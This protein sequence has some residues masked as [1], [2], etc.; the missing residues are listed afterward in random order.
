M[1]L[2]VRVLLVHVVEHGVDDDA[3]AV[4]VRVLH[5]RL[6]R[7]QIAEARLHVAAGDRPVAVIAGVQVVAGA[8]EAAVGVGVR[9]RQPERAHAERVEVALVDRRSRCPRIAALIIGARVDA[10]GRLVVRRIAV[11]EAIGEGEVHEAVAEVE[12]LILDPE[13]QR[14][15]RRRRAPLLSAAWTTRR[16]L[17]LASPVASTVMRPLPSSVAPPAGLPSSVTATGATSRPAASEPSRYCTSAWS[18]P[19]AVL[20]ERLELQQRQLAVVDLDDRVL[21]AADELRVRRRRIELP[22]RHAGARRW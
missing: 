18:A 21:D 12:R 2:P 22:R 1:H 16:C 6:Q 9:R 14:A 13:R 5:E 4:R 10:G 8:D 7:R 17:V 11:A 3:D 19:S 15:D 20:V